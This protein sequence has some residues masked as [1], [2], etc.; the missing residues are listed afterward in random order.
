MT[1]TGSRRIRSKSLIH[2][3]TSSRDSIL[4][5]SSSRRLKA[6]ADGSTRSRSLRMVRRSRRL[7]AIAR[8]GSGIPP[9]ALTS[10]HLKDKGVSS[11]RAPN[12]RVARV[13]A[14]Y[15]SGIPPRARTSRHSM[16]MSLSNKFPFLATGLA[17]IPTEGFLT[18][19]MES[20]VN[21]NSLL[22]RLSSL[23]S[24]G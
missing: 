22:L 5:L 10:R 16:L 14:R 21:L 11:S 17:Y 3:Q 4:F 24:N 23:K 20:P 6:T 9:R 18:L 15:G 8:Y 7:R 12:H 13:I 2:E 1:K 19:H